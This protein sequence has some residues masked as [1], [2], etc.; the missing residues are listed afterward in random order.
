M[1]HRR[2]LTMC[3]LVG[4]LALIGAAC[5]DTSSTGTTDS[6][7]STG[8]ACRAPAYGGV[9]WIFGTRDLAFSS[10]RVNRQTRGTVSDHPLVDVQVVI[11]AH[12]AG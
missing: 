9:D 12:D 8:G 5:S 2:L 10:W 4:V 3:A 11:A 7:G 6:G 1:T